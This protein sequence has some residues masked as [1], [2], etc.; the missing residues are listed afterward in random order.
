MKK[1]NELKEMTI[2]DLQ[3]ELLAMRKDQFNL[4]MRKANGSLDKPHHIAAVRKTIARIKT[5]MTQKA[6][7]THA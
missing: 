7:T 3:A 5:M 2:N 4:R 1:T 6:G